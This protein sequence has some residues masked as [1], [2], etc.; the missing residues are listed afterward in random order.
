MKIAVGADHRG[1]AVKEQV[2]V[3]LG[4]QGHDVVDMGTNSSRSCDYPDVAYPV[5][6]AVADARVE[7]AILIDGNGLGMSICANKVAGV[8]AALCHDE[9]TAEMSRRHNNSNILCLASDV[10]GEEL[11]RRIVIS[12]LSTEFEG[13]GR[14]ERRVK[15]LNWVEQGNDPNEYAEA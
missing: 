7:R 8:R 6:R 13:G 3:L 1:Q 5:S 9:L 2:A 10:L 12:W 15:K 11:V 4:E 14:H